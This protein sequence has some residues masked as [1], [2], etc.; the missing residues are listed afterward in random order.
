M[1]KRLGMLSAIVAV[2]LAL[3]VAIIYGTTHVLRFL[4]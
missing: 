2:D 3:W 1:L 4:K